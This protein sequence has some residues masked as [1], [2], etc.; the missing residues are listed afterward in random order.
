MLEQCIALGKE[1]HGDEGPGKDIAR[2]N[3]SCEKFQQG[4]IWDYIS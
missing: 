2:F 3:I 1:T 4:K